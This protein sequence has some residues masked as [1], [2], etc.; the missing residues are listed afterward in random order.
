MNLGL[1][2]TLDKIFTDFENFIAN[3]SSNPILWILI[4]AVILIIVA[5]AYNVLSK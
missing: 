1:I 2:D 5:A 4:L 3:H